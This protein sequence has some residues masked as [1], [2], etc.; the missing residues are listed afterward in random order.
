MYRCFI[1]KVSFCLLLLVLL[2]LLPAADA[3][4]AAAD[5]DDAVTDKCISC[6]MH[7]Y[8]GLSILKT[9]YLPCCEQVS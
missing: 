1:N 3:S 2:V 6:N 4:A 9:S 8:I 5:D 7:K